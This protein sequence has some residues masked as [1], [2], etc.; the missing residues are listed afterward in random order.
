LPDIK[1]QLTIKT[2]KKTKQKVKP[3]R[4]KTS[5]SWSAHTSTRRPTTT[6][7][8]QKIRFN[9]HTHKSGSIGFELHRSGEWREKEKNE[10]INVANE[11]E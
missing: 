10:K 8:E 4:Q 11:N 7:T 9:T 6:T 3:F 2:Y 1:S 5:Q